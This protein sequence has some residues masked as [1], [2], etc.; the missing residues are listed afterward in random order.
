MAQLAAV[1]SIEPAFR[2]IP[3]L[4]GLT[5]WNDSARSLP[6]FRDESAERWCLAGSRVVFAMSA[7]DLLNGKVEPAVPQNK[8]VLVG[9]SAPGFWTYV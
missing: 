2:L 8:I 5:R 7:T 9:T 4:V 6:A 3:D 1:D